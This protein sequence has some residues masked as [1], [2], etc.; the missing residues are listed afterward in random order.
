MI[1]QR[2]LHIALIIFL[3]V[4]SQGS[5]AQDLD[6]LITGQDQ[7]DRVI[8]TAVPFLGFAPDSRGSALGFSGVAT[9]PDINSVHWNNA[10]LAFTENKWG[11]S[12]SYMPWLNN[13]TSDMYVGYLAGTFKLDEVQAFSS[14]FRYFDRGH[15]DILDDQANILGD[16]GPNE[17]AFDATY[18]RKLSTK[19]SVGL[20]FRYI[21]SNISDITNPDNRGNSKSGFSTDLGF[22]YITDIEAQNM[23]LSFGAHLSN[24]GPKI[25]YI[26]G[27]YFLPVNLRL[28]TSIKKYIDDRNSIAL[29]LDLNKLLVPTPPVVVQNPQTGE[30]EIIG[31]RTTDRS[32]LSGVFGSFA[33]APSGFSEE[34]QEI[35]ISVGVEYWYRELAS[36]RLGYFGEN[37]HKGARK[38]ITTGIGFRYDEFGLDLSYLIPTE[39]DHALG[40]TIQLTVSAAFNGTNE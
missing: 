28:G 29:S 3:T 14:T 13:L 5:K 1:F 31:G 39:Q 11:T 36:L 15:F 23:L 26:D 37:D 7:R 20:T 25:S 9:A 32:L 30:T 34:M 17:L 12:A 10:K 16:F 27:E 4:C 19:I 24:F 33:D 18:A 21:L 38:L 2:L 22:Y 8:I 40:N 35:S 6:P